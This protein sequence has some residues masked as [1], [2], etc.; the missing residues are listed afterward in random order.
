MMAIPP[1]GGW[2]GV[3]IVMPTASRAAASMLRPMTR[4]SVAFLAPMASRAAASALGARV[5]IQR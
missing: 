2:H 5:L 4:W 3:A 1:A